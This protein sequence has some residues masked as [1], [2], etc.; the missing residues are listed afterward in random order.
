MTLPSSLRGGD[1][2]A[3]GT[4]SGF[5]AILSRGWW[6]VLLRGLLA[7]AFAALVQLLPDISLE[8]L[9][10]LFATLALADGALTAWTAIAG[11]REHDDWW[12]LL[13]GGLVGIGIGVVTLTA[14]HITGLLLL[15]YVAIWAITKGIIEIAVAV[16]L[17]REIVGEWALI[18]GPISIGFGALL[19]A[20]PST[21]A[22]ARLGAIGTYCV[23]FG[24]ILGAFSVKARAFGRR[25]AS[26]GAAAAVGAAPATPADGPPRH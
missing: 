11:L 15:L 20:Q 8:T 5:A 22:L 24:A 3:D 18:Q 19:M 1:R 16:R 14:P 2:V 12:V 9:V 4:P 7:L 23:I 17:P 26:E 13:L 6:A 10:S 25:V 21:G